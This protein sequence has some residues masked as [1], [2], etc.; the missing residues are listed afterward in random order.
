MLDTSATHAHLVHDVTCTE[1]LTKN[2][3]IHKRVFST[4]R[5]W[6]IETRI[7][8]ATQ[9]KAAKYFS[10]F[11][12]FLSLLLL[13]LLL[14]LILS[15]WPVMFLSFLPF[16]IFMED[17]V[18]SGQFGKSNLQRPLISAWC[19]MTLHRPTLVNW[20]RTE[21]APGPEL[22][23]LHSHSAKPR[24]RTDTASFKPRIRTDTA[25]FTLSQ[26]TDQHWH[27]FI[28]AT[29]QNWHG[30]IQVT[31]QNWHGFIQATVQNWHGFVNTQPSHS[32]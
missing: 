28:Q 26:A 8:T 10:L 12:F 6:F 1:C 17:I 13:L 14:L 15:I 18:G 11:S 22:T 30:F 3:S 7:Y 23:L 27:G 31:D 29:D 9:L 24:I 4:F 32:L 21:V 5:L 19:A 20:V 25:T 2:G 16:N